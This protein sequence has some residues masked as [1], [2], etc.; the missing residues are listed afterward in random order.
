MNIPRKRRYPYR[1]MERPPHSWCGTFYENCRPG[2]DPFD[3][4][5]ACI[6]TP[7]NGP[8]LVEGNDGKRYWVDRETLTS[9]WEKPT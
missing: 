2:D 8:C 5:A 9:S 6:L 3:V 4:Y 7:H 1:P